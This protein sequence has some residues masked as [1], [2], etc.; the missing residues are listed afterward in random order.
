MTLSSRLKRP[1]GWVLLILISAV[2]QC[3]SNSPPGKPV[4]KQCRSPDK[5]TFTCWWEPGANDG[6]NT[7]YRLLYEKDQ[8]NRI[9]ECPDYHSA[10]KNSCFFDK[11]HT[12]I[13][14]DYFLTLVA[15]NA[16]GNTT[17]DVYKFDVVDIV[18]PN[19]PE[20]VTLWLE[21]SEAIPTVHVTWNP[22]N[23]GSKFGWITAKYQLRFKKEDNEWN[24][25]DAGIQ[26]HFSLY[27]ASPGRLYTVQVRCALDNG[28]WSEWSN[29][30]IIHVPLSE[31]KQQQFW[32][33]VSFFSAVL[34]FA[35]VGVMFIK[36]KI[37]KQWLLPPV[38][39]PKIKGVD[40]QLL[41][42]G[43]S[44][45][46][47]SALQ[48]NPVLP[49]GMPW[50]NQSEEYLV[51]C[52]DNMK[53]IEDQINANGIMISNHF[54]SKLKISNQ[55]SV[56][57]NVKSKE[58]VTIFSYCMD[59]S[60]SGVND[61][62]Y[63]NATETK[64]ALSNDKNKIVN[65]KPDENSSYVDIQRHEVEIRP[66]D[67]STAREHIL[68][69]EKLNSIDTNRQEESLPDDY[70]RVK[71]V[72]SDN[73]VLLQDPPSKNHAQNTNCSDQISSQPVAG[74]VGVCAES[75]SGYVD[76]SCAVTM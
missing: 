13:W 41:K 3:S 64:R 24:I 4:L 60:K 71:E 9:L 36:R 76:N 15:I 52:D 21:L 63:V 5:E 39:G 50:K 49:S 59:I 55:L 10:G 57:N 70:T 14:V 29:T 31:S 40:V 27:S 58:Q 17:S 46:L 44:E 61:L 18:K 35:A 65:V 26:T 1:V 68:I 54:H 22:Y 25:K 69:S 74:K 45:E 72:N 56:P 62:N 51:V 73:V 28:A 32:I 75:F 16:F 34:F 53:L 43:R 66:T 38:P 48:I 19:P 47:T 37:I 42:N 2:F 11:T 8:T 20:N 6:E 30:A 12:S 23:I 33:L 7:T 67:Y